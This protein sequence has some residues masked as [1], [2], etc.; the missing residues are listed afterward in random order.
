MAAEVVHDD[1]VARPQDGHEN[2]LDIGAKTHAIDRSVDDAGRGEPVATQRRQESEGPPFAER[3]LGDQAFASG[4]AAV[5]ARHIG[6]GPG[7]VD[8]DKPPRIDRRLTRLPPLTPPGD[9]RPVLFGGAKAFFE[10]HPFVMEKMPKSI[11]ADHQA[12]V[13]QFPEQRAQGEIRL[14]RDPRQNPIPFAR[15]KVRPAAAH[16]QRRRTA[17]GAVALRPLHNAGD[18]DHECLGR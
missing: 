11:V 4:A 8:E 10:R 7:L 6:F 2:L 9:V 17:D 14:L 3:R 15:Y 13:G 5:G 18:A 1:N 12:A 16:F